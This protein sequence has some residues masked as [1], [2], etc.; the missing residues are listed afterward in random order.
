[1]VWG[2]GGL[3]SLVEYPLLKPASLNGQLQTHGQADGPWRVMKQNGQ[4]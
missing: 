3:L 2:G 4:I 1:M